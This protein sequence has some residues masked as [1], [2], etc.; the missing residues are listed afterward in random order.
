VARDN[1]LKDI[2]FNPVRLPRRDLGPADVLLTD[3]GKEPSK[4]GTLQMLLG[5]EA[6]LPDTTGGEPMADFGGEFTRKLDVGLGI[7]I[8]GALL[9]ASLAGKLG[10]DTGLSR[11]KELH[12]SYEDVTQDSM[13]VIA[14]QGW[15]EAADLIAPNAV[16]VWLNGKKLAVVTATLRTAKLS[17]AAKSSRGE[18]VALSVPE[19]EGIVGANAKVAAAGSDG[20]TVSF[21]GAEPLVFA[22]Q[23]FTM[24]Y[25]DSVNLGLAQLRGREIDP[26]S[27]AWTSEYELDELGDVDTPVA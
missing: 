7:S 26:T 23:A 24:L 25:D 22:F 14:L 4:A 9:G 3:G 13:P 15:M 16:V 18:S 2:G 5:S 8:L 11:A 17:V 27:Q 1:W 19:I 10:V 12:V 20:T 21:E 6:A